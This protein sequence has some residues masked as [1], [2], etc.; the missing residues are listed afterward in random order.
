MWEIVT[1]TIYAW[2]DEEYDAKLN[3]LA[4]E[5]WEPFSSEYEQDGRYT[6]RLKRRKSES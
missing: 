4:E 1:R 3:E 5:G 2:N 6:V